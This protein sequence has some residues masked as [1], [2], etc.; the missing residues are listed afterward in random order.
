MTKEH[1]HQYEPVPIDTTD[2]D[3][4]QE[5]LQLTELLAENAHENW[6]RKRMEEGWRQGPLRDDKAKTHPCLVPY[7]ALP[8]SEKEHDRITATET[9][10]LIVK[11]GY[12]VISPNAGGS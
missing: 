8:E 5:L 6:A 10:R 2:V 9:I 12:R 1:A 7:R 3:L 4:P 11:L